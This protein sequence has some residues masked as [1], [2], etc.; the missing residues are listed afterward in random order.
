MHRRRR[1]FGV[2]AALLLI[3]GGAARGEEAT[4]LYQAYWGG[5]PAGQIRLSLRD[6]AAGYHD[7]VHIRATGVSRMLINFR[8]HAISEGRF[9]AGRPPEPGQYD[10]YYDLRK[11]RDRRLSMIFAP[12]AGAL[13]AARGPGDT[14]KKPPLAEEFRRNV[15]DPLTALTA[16]RQQLRLGDRDRFT[17][18]VYDGARRFDVIVRVRSRDA[19]DP[20]LHV[21][22]M[23]SPIA[24]FK[25]ESSDDGDPENA[26]RPAHVTF[27]NDSRL[28]PLMMTVSIAHLPLVVQL[29]RWCSADAPCGW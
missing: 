23:L 4:A 15:F 6:E 22:L 8:G 24:G 21:D 11:M 18:P 2:A 3:A 17:V 1:L 13:V 5:L 7:E 19:G 16:I 25:G 9:A 10:A 29:S 27:S 28:M 12:Q 20:M 26:P 14:S